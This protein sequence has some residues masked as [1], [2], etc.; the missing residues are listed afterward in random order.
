MALR[1]AFMGTPDFAAP[2][3]AEL[4]GQGHQIAAVYSQPARPKG[5]GLAAEPS[6]VAKLAEAYELALRTPVSLKDDEEQARFRRARSRCGDGGGLWAAVAQGGAGCAT[7]GLLQS[8]WLA[9][10]ALARRR[11]D[12]ARDHGGRCETGVM[13]MRMEEGLDTGP[14][15]MAER[16]AIG[17]KT[18]GELHDELSRLGADLM[19]R[20]LAALERGSIE[21]Q[22]AAGSTASPMRKKFTKTKRASIGQSRR[23]EID[24][25]IRGLSPVPGAWCEAKGER[26]KIL[27]AEPV[28]GQGR[29]GE[30]LGRCADGRLRRWRAVAE[31]RAARGQ[32]ADGGDRSAPRLRA[33]QRHE[34]DMTSAFQRF[35]REAKETRRR[36]RDKATVDLTE[37]GFVFT[38]R[39]Q[40]VAVCW[41]DVTKLSAG[42]FAMTTGEVYFV[43]VAAGAMEVQIDEF[44]D[45]FAIFERALIERY[46]QIRERILALQT[47]ASRHDRL[48]EL[49]AAG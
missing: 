34:A 5:R 47:T 42:T 3:L 17:R 18:Y 36:R 35:M 43:R 44:A 46:P 19:A 38:C 6:P 31:A 15:L 33:A 1:L 13:V 24:C 28:G 9:S 49:W 30:M 7:A 12:P 45:G 39:G 27:Y 14:V 2:T 48:V 8:S 40:P 25:L 20:A 23:A 11:T 26:L 4:V 22:A 10:A 29:P 41:D 16:A 32:G 21:E 37:D